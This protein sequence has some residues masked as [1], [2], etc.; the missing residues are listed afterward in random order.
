VNVFI[1]TEKMANFLHVTSINNQKE[2]TTG[3]FL[4]FLKHGNDEK[5]IREVCIKSSGVSIRY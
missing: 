4:T 5:E 2:L 1:I 3:R